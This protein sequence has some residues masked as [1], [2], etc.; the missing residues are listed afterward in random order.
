MT[1]PKLTFLLER[2]QTL[3][4]LAN[5]PSAKVP[6][7]ALVTEYIPE[8]CKVPYDYLFRHNGQAM[9][10]CTLLVQDYLNL[11]ILTANMDVYNFEAEAMGAKIKFFPDHCPDFDRSDYFIKDPS[12][13]NKIRFGGLDQGRFPYLIQYCKA[14]KHYTGVDTFPIFSAPWTLAG[15]LYGIENLIMATIEDPEFVNEF[16]RRI[17]DDYHVPMFHALNDAVPGFA[18]MDFV[19]AFASVPM[20]NVSI[21]NEFIR[22]YLQRELDK[23]NMPRIRLMDTA[24]FGTAM[25]E[26]KDRESFEDF[27]I[28]SN[29]RFLCIDPDAATL[30]ADYAREVATRHMTPLQIG[31]SATYLEFE[32][33]D[34]I[35]ALV[36]DYVLKAKSGPTPAIFFFN[37]ISPCT[38]QEKIQAAVQAVKIY[39]APGADAD[40]PYQIPEFRSFEEFLKYKLKNNPEEY[41]FEWVK[42]SA[43]SYLL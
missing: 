3:Q 19:D 36:R 15:N 5:W 10:E 25:L 34:N 24:F 42:Q 4:N 13:L 6:V 32:S 30:G 31:I 35:V 23:L 43:Y 2:L 11:D 16:L 20:V 9:A 28:W 12:D 1:Q 27:I 38:E 39:G 37:N 33:I 14:Y 26:G 21:V 18:E 41:T 17:V 29:G 8:L 7:T 40:T 22:P